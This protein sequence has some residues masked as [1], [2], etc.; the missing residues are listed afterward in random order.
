[1]AT[2]TE[3]GG[4]GVVGTYVCTKC[5]GSGT[6]RQLYPVTETYYQVAPTEIMFHAPPLSPTQA[7]KVAIDYQAAARATLRTMGFCETTTH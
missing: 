3:C 4:K 5:N 1:M 6:K 7:L 2:C